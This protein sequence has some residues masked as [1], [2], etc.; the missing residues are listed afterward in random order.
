MPTDVLEGNRW[1]AEL[2]RA[3]SSLKPAGLFTPLT[4]PA[5]K[6]FEAPALRLRSAAPSTGPPS[7]NGSGTTRSWLPTRAPPVVEGYEPGA[8]GDTCVYDAA[9][10]KDLYARGGGYS[11]T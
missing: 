1:Q 11:A 4:F 8:C 7:S 3:T 5:D 9:A 2:G 6:R 10:A